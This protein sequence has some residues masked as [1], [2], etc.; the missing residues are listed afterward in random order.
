MTKTSKSVAMQDKKNFKKVRAYPSGATGSMIEHFA[1]NKSSLL[2][3]I[4]K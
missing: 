3:K 2:L 4:K 1:L